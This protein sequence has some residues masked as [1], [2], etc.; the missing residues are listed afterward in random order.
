MEKDNG[1]YMTFQI[2]Q[3]PFGFRGLRQVM[4]C[5]AFIGVSIWQHQTIFQSDKSL[6]KI[7]SICQNMNRIAIV[8][9]V[10]LSLAL[11][12]PACSSK[13]L[14]PEVARELV[15]VMFYG[16]RPRL[17]LADIQ[18]EGIQIDDYL[19]VTKRYSPV[20]DKLQIRSVFASKLLSWGHEQEAWELLQVP[21]RGLDDEEVGCWLDLRFNASV[22]SGRKQSPENVNFARSRG[23]QPIVGEDSI[24]ALINGDSRAALAEFRQ[25]VLRDGWNRRMLDSAAM[26]LRASARNSKDNNALNLQREIS[27]SAYEY[28]LHDRS[29]K[30]FVRVQNEDDPA[31]ADSVYRDDLIWIVGSRIALEKLAKNDEAVLA[32]SAKMNDIVAFVEKH[33][34]RSVGWVKFVRDEYFG[35]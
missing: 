3:P 33:R 17:K 15:G 14:N 30:D 11:L 31:V 12:T 32:W 8:P 2:Q 34:D 26:L 5:N 20:G 25:G 7:E 1:C 6:T 22:L 28:I 29:W 23:W 21:P 13:N 4:Y 24:G 16:E 9:V 35:R 27:E 18:R 19:P 10:L